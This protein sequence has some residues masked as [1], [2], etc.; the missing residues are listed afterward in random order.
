MAVANDNGRVTASGLA[1]DLVIRAYN[2]S[3]GVKGH[4][5]PLDLNSSNGEVTA[6]DVFSKQIKV[7]SDNGSVRMDLQQVPERVS[8]VSSNGKVDIAVPGGAGVAYRVDASSSDGNVDVSVPQ[9]NHS[10]RRLTVRSD[11]GQVRVR[12]AN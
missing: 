5:G 6:E 4:H 8:A 2:G 11:N 1:K 12:T 7:R 10:H 3:V 9:D